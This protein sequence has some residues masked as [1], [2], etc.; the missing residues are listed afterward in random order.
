MY[1][2]DSCEAEAKVAELFGPTR[3]ICSRPGDRLRAAIHSMRI[4][5]VLLAQVDYGASVELV[6]DAPKSLFVAQTVLAGRMHSSD[7]DGSRVLGSGATFLYAPGSPFHLALSDRC[8]R[9]CV[10]VNSGRLQQPEFA[11]AERDGLDRAASR[12]PE[13]ALRWRALVEYLGT[14]MNLRI[15][16]RTSLRYASERK[17]EDWIISTMLDCWMPPQAGEEQSNAPSYLVSAVE[18]IEAHFDH[19]LTI[20][21]V[22]RHSRVS[23]RMLQMSFRKFKGVTPMSFLKTVRLERARA[24]LQSGAQSRG[25]VTRVALEHGF[26]HLGQ[27]AIEY[28]QR[29]GESP[30]ETLQRS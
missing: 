5:D 30:S 3:L 22:A 14:E 17:L 10:V 7:S 6:S 29:F 9:F 24:A 11:A 16:D 26:A 12:R 2:Y 4:G 18:Y 15:K 25:T 23:A 8:T 1:T 28:K 19:P 21:D 20:D 27:F 13:S